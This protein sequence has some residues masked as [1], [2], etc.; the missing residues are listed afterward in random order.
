MIVPTSIFRAYDVRG[1]VDNTL[2]D[3]IV[4]ALGRA[5]GS[6]AR[7]QGWTQVVIGRDGRLSGP[8]YAQ[9]LAMG[10]QAAGVDVI[11]IGQAPTPVLYFAAQH[12][13]IGSGIQVTGSHNPPDYNGFKMVLGGVTLAEEA[14]QRL[15]HRMEND[16]YSNGAGRYEQRA[17][18]DEYLARIVSDITPARPLKIVVDCGNG[19]AGAL[20]PTLLR[21]LG[22]TVTELFC[23]V[24][25]HFPNHHPDPSQPE[26]LADLIRTVQTQQAD[27]GLAFDGD[28]DRLGV[29]DVDGR[30]IWPDR[31]MML[32]ARD[33]LVRHPGSQIIF[34]VKCSVHLKRDIERHGGVPVMWKTGHSLI[35][36]KLKATGAPLAGEM[37]GHIFFKE[38]WYG[39]DDALYTAARLIEILARE[40][41]SPAAVF[42][43]LPDS[44]NTPELRVDLAE[45]EQITFMEALR[46]A[47]RFDDADVI[48]I[49]GLRVE[50]PHGWG[51]CRASNTTPS[52]VLRFEA[53]DH[54]ALQNIQERLR[55]VMI[56]VKPDI[57]LPF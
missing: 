36:A 1:I 26:N 55:A 4:R 34:D 28:G 47:A 5:F 3:D 48:T 54:A 9:M 24:D 22:C 15:R 32:Y 21:Q 39:F 43:A 37:S 7:A 19:V 33:I 2:T 40:V 52:L 46:A 49:D 18:T 45:G 17:I 25:G 57:V 50:F 6:E 14:I 10:L 56:Q 41:R 44:V 13:G 8:R 29:V 42:A 23:E 27:L 30:V 12:F 16:D 35:K 53:D 51:L 31:Q 20:A 38:R 11:D